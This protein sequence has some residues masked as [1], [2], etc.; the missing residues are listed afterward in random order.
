[1]LSTPR[2]LEHRAGNEI[3]NNGLD[4][5]RAQSLLDRERKHYWRKMALRGLT[6]KKQNR[7]F[8]NLAKAEQRVVASKSFLQQVLDQI[9]KA[10]ETLRDSLAAGKA[11]LEND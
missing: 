4:V 6:N 3:Y 11:A 5:H 7:L 1:M 10:V 9:N 8:R 2:T